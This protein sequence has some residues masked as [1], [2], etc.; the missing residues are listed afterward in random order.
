MLLVKF[1][2]EAEKLHYCKCMKKSD[3]QVTEHFSFCVPQ[4]KR[5]SYDFV[6]I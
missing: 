4:K 6:T 1:I 2:F 5:S 3:K